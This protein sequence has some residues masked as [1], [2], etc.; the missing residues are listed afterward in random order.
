M[1]RMTEHFTSMEEWPWNLLPPFLDKHVMMFSQ[2]TL[3]LL[4]HHSSRVPVFKHPEIW[5]SSLLSLKA[6]VIR[7]GLKNWFG[8]APTDRRRGKR[9]RC[10][11][12]SL[13]AIW[14]GETEEERDWIKDIQKTTCPPPPDHP[15]GNQCVALP[16]RKT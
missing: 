10:E 13:A 4:L 1:F 14:G 12:A 11:W 9:G 7:V 6:G 2:D 16:V 3:P 15:E 5:L 8:P